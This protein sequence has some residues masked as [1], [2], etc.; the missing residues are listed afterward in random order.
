MG[1]SIYPQSPLLHFMH[2]PDLATEKLTLYRKRLDSLQ[3]GCKDDCSWNPE[4]YRCVTWLEAGYIIFWWKEKLKIWC[5]FSHIRGDWKR[6]SIEDFSFPL[7]VGLP[8]SQDRPVFRG[9]CYRC[10]CWTCAVYNRVRFASE[11][12]AVSSC[13]ILFRVIFNMGF[14]FSCGADGCFFKKQTQINSPIFSRQHTGE[15]IIVIPSRQQRYIAYR[16]ISLYIM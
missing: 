9:L 12:N 4:L 16:H 5:V 3:A 7:E 8:P 1:S 15:I 11:M 6:V 2:F 10:L 13:W 14:F